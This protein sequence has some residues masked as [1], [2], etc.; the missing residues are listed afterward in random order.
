M[1]YHYSKRFVFSSLVGGCVHP[2]TVCEIICKESTNQHGGLLQQFV[3]SSL[4]DTIIAKTSTGKGPEE[5]IQY[6]PWNPNCVCAFGIYLLSQKLNL[7]FKN[8][9]QGKWLDKVRVKRYAISLRTKST[10]FL[11]K[12]AIKLTILK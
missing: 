3:I 8:G 1:G 5:S 4:L 6:S 9:P 11:Y 12:Y 2:V 7:Q 10:Y